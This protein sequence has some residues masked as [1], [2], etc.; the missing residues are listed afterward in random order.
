L[1]TRADQKVFSWSGR[2]INVLVPAPDQVLLQSGSGAQPLYWARL[3]PAAQALAR[4]LIDHEELTLGKEI[5]ELGAGLGLP[6]LAAAANARSVL[7]TDLQ[8][9]AIHWVQR[10]AA[11]NGITN[12]E[13]KVA[14]WNDDLPFYPGLLLL[15]DVNYDPSQFRGLHHRLR[16][17][18]EAGIP[19]LLSTPQR[20]TAREFVQDL[21]PFVC[22]SWTT[23]ID[24]RGT[25]TDVTVFFLQR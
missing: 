19:I 13:A 1:I 3:W 25:T 18:I 17:W 10:S 6:S 14:D 4:Y 2:N 8:N 16:Q 21:L 5:I 22:E 15:S 20:L 12:L 23:T 24:E 7:C 11:A 9:E